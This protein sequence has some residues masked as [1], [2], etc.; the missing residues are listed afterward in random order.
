VTA[1]CTVDILHNFALNQPASQIS[2]YSTGV[3]SLAVDGRYDMPLWRSCT[4]SH[5]H[6][7]WSVD[8]GAEYYVIRVIVTNDP[9]AAQR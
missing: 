1:H 4:E 7:W 3:A 5:V 8:L 9:E 6:P 2:T